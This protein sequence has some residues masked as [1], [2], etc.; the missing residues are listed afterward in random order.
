MGIAGGVYPLTGQG[1]GVAPAVQGDGERIRSGYVPG[2]SGQ[3]G[4]VQV[5]VCIQHQGNGGILAE[6][7]V[8]LQRTCGI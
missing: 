1:N 8:E 2:Q 3:A 5:N 7:S 4:A 6:I